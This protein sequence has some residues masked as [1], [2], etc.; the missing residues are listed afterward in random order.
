MTQVYMYYCTN[1]VSIDHMISCFLSIIL[2]TETFPSGATTLCY[3]LSFMDNANFE[4]SPVLETTV[5][6]S[7][8][9]PRVSATGVTHVSVVDDDGMNNVITFYIVNCALQFPLMFTD[10]VVLYFNFN[11]EDF[12]K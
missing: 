8:L 2:V 3:Q 4:S 6:L 5:S 9:N 12:K 11:P 7:S 1:V 10:N